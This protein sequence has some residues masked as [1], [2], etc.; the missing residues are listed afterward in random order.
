MRLFDRLTR[1]YGDTY[2]EYQYSGAQEVTFSW[3]NKRQQEGPI[4]ILTQT[5]RLY[6]EN[7]VVFAAILARLM[8]FSEVQF[9]Y[10]A[11]A[12]HRL[13]GNN[14]D[15][16]L[17]RVEHPWPNGTTGELLARMI[18]DADLAGNCYIWNTGEQL[19]R[20]NPRFVT[21]VSEEVTDGH[22]RKYRK[23]LGYYYDPSGMTNGRTGPSE[24]AQYFDVAE[25]AHWSP[26]PDPMATF[27]GMSWLTPVLRE[28]NSDQALTEYKIRY[29]ENA[30]TPNI[31]IRYKQKLQKETIDDLRER[32][33]ARY[34]GVT[35]AFKTLILDQ[36]ADTTIVG[37]HL[38]QVGFTTVQAA[39]ENRILMASGV[40]G[41]VVGSKEG[42]QAATY[43]NYKQAV[44]RFD[45]LTIRP[46]WRSVCACL[47]GPVVSVP[48]GS[49]LW[50][51]TRNIAALQDDETE[52]AAATQVRADAIAKLVQFNFDPDSVVKAVETGDLNLL[53]HSGPVVDMKGGAV[54][55][56]RPPGIKYDVTT[57]E[58]I[59]AKPNGNESGARPLGGAAGAG[60]T[61]AP[62]A[63][64]GKR[65]GF[66]TEDE[67]DRQIIAALNARRQD[68]Q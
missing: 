23:L 14:A 20:L 1:R 62:A 52:K 50:F 44:K 15:D 3:G 67:L 43:S 63:L 56:A 22:G 25:I 48:A 8:L 66:P 42:L 61:G 47:D 4:E 29:M 34:G 13:W 51:D 39:G 18:Q 30:A 28:I 40:P 64:N 6:K 7:G 26:I 58:P 55:L 60:S 17:V 24:D 31:M 11:V 54:P 35:N 53:K 59:T 46:L 16:G 19:V 12:D 68:G 27:R 5:N 37:A 21:I 36:G 32:M 45:T 57:G 49:R 10:Q 9:Q 2:N 41:I 38:E 65:A 33:H